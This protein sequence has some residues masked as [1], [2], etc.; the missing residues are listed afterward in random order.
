MDS[1]I[2]VT[3]F[4]KKHNLHYTRKQFEQVG[5]P[6]PVKKRVYWDRVAP[7]FYYNE[8]DLSECAERIERVD[9]AIKDDVMEEI[10][11]AVD[12]LALFYNVKPSYVKTALENNNG[13]PLTLTQYIGMRSGALPAE[14]YRNARK[15]NSVKEERQEPRYTIKAL[16]K[17]TEQLRT[18]RAKMNLEKPKKASKPKQVNL[19]TKPTDATHIWNKSFFKKKRDRY[20]RWSPTAKAWI[21]VRRADVPIEKLKEL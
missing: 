8:V 6:K 1:P 16:D 12:L 17:L 15:P 3:G 18:N 9:T 2:T 7:T 4:I 19:F 20:F 14:K 10:E 5:L 13:Q 11:K 21:S